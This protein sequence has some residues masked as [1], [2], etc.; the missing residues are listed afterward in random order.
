MI[1]K[2][3]NPYTQAL[4]NC[5]SQ[6][7]KEPEHLDVKN[8]QFLANMIQGRFLQYLVTRIGGYHDI[9]SKDLEKKLSMTFLKL[10]SEKFFALFREK[11][12][13]KPEIVYQIARTIVDYETKE[14]ISPDQ[15]DW[16]YLMISKEYFAYQNFQIIID[17]INA[18]PEVEKI[19]FL[20]RVEKSFSDPGLLR[21]FHHILN[22]DPQGLVPKIFARYLAKGKLE[23]VKNLVETG[24]WHFE[25]DYVAKEQARWINW[26]NYIAQM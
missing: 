7:D 10:L 13:Q 8:S 25:A 18:N 12:K 20:A 11:V 14:L 21:A 15:I 22:Q 5:L 24:D 19:I 6:F 3:I 1:L 4:V 2:P 16:L 9:T 26:H 23:R 17:W